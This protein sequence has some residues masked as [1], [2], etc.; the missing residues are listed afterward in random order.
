M[1]TIFSLVSHVK[2]LIFRRGGNI[3]ISS[4]I[5]S[6]KH[7][8]LR[9]IKRP[10]VSIYCDINTKGVVEHERRLRGT[11]EV[12]RDVAECFSDFS[13]ALQLT[14]CLYHSI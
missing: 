1:V 2:I 4:I 12:A 8:Y 9:N 11:R 14:S 5:I 13:S 10:R 6:I 7:I 3:G